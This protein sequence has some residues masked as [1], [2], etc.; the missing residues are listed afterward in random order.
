MGSFRRLEFKALCKGP[1]EERARECVERARYYDM[2][3]KFHRLSQRQQRVF[4]AAFQAML[5]Q[6]GS[7]EG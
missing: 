2:M 7:G 1:N 5:E 6:P 4:M 3:A